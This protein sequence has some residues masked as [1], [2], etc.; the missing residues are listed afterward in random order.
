MRRAFEA[1]Q[2]ANAGFYSETT[3]V[4]RAQ[5]GIA[6]IHVGRNVPVSGSRAR[7]MEAMH[8]TTSSRFQG[9]ASIAQ[10]PR[11]VGDDLPL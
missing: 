9:K 8:C 11:Q 10:A 7:E 2:E 6:A 5:I 1:S 3:I 4:G